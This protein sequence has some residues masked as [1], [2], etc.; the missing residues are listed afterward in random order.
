MMMSFK[1]KF[2]L[3]FNLKMDNIQQASKV[4]KNAIKFKVNF[5][6]YKE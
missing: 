6:L 1:S 3:Q 2:Q 5:L 4:W